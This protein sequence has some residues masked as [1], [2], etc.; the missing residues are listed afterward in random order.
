MGPAVAAEEVP[1]RRSTKR[2]FI[3]G[4][5]RASRENWP[6][7]E[8]YYKH[9]VVAPRKPGKLASGRS[10]VQ[11]LRGSSAQAGKTGLR[12]EFTTSIAW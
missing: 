10:L 6:P 5:L 2:Y 7:G 1:T 9:C 3:A 12:V 11:A 4:F 8:I